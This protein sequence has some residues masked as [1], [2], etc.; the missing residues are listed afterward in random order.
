MKVNLMAEYLILLPPPCTNSGLHMGHLAGVYI[1]GDMYARYLL[2]RGHDVKVVCGADQNN[3]YTELKSQ[4]IKKSF[5][6]TKNFYADEILKSLKEAGIYVHA[7]SFTA[8]QQ[9]HKVVKE[10]VHLLLNNNFLNVKEVDQFYCTFCAE[11][12]CDAAVQGRCGNCY[13]D[14]SAAICENCNTPRFNNKLVEAIHTKCGH[15]A[16]LKPTTI[17]VLNIHSVKEIF[18]YLIDNSY[19]DDRLKAKYMEYLS[20]EEVEDIVVTNHYEHG[21]KINHNFLNAKALTIWIEALWSSFTALLEIYETDLQALFSR[22]RDADIHLIPFMG[23]DT[24]FYYA[25]AFSAVLLGLGIKKI[26]QNMSVQRFVKLNGKKFSSSQNHII[27]VEQLREKFPIEIIRLYSIS[28][29]M[30]YFE[31]SNNFII[32]DLNKIDEK[33]NKLKRKMKLHSRLWKKEED[34]PAP[35]IG[36]LEIINNYDVAMQALYFSEVYKEIIHLIDFILLS[37]SNT[38][39]NFEIACCLLMLNPIMPTLV[40]DLGGSF[41]GAQWPLLTLEKLQLFLSTKSQVRMHKEE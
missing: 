15:T 28:V 6:Y 9:H 4:K 31:N 30:P 24:E 5:E 11:Y 12:L 2:M 29:L 27:T 40:E 34:W 19:W 25:I 14:S 13:S 26:P 3:I 7:F 16:V 18:K 33:F 39:L 41:Y 35:S 21:I 1:P 17:F 38:G 36:M 10:I 20:R 8:S 22:L 23:E 32:E 37:D